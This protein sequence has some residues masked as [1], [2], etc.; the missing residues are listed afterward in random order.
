DGPA[1]KT[2]DTVTVDSFLPKGSDHRPLVQARV[3]YDD[4]GLYV[5]FRVE[6]RY[7]RCVR[8]GLQV[9]T[10]DD[11]CVEFF[12]EPKGDLG[13]FNFEM[14]CGGAL[15]CHHITYKPSSESGDKTFTF[16]DL[17]WMKKVRR[18]HSMPEVVEPEVTDP[19]TWV[20]EFHVPFAFFEA[21]V[22]ELP[23]LPDNPWRG[24]FQKLAMESS[25]PHYAAW[26]PIGGNGTFHQPEFFATLRFGE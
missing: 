12:I 7:V 18:Y 5:I 25:H 21:H 20:V 4:W 2:A 14:S 9:R 3:L 22:G 8:T 24:N 11:S 19:V 13:Y 15:L 1:W 16:V 23:S 10:C 6:D 26:S 17:E